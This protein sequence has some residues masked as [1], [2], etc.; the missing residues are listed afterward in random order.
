MGLLRNLHKQSFCLSCLGSIRGIE[1]HNSLLSFNFPL[2]VEYMYGFL[3]VGLVLQ[4][5]S[6]GFGGSAEWGLG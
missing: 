4:S 6:S 2:S 5:L 3:S 1:G